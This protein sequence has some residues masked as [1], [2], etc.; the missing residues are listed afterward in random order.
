VS[1]RF[2]DFPSARDDLR[3]DVLAG[4]TASPKS[5]PPKYFYDETGCR[6]FEAICQQPEYVLTRTELSLMRGK[7]PEIAAAIGAVDCIVEPGAGECAKVRLLIDALRAGGLG[8]EAAFR[9]AFAAFAVCSAAAYAWF[10]L[11]GR[12]AIHNPM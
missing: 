9:W 5:I 1:F 11:D 10:V 7:L 4:L 3:A 2:I 6:L 12:R 8:D